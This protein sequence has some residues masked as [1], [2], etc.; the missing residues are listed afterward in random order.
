[1]RKLFSDGTYAEGWAVYSE[2]MMLKEGFR[3]GD[4]GLELQMLKMQLKVT[5]NAILDIKLHRGLMREDEVVPFLL[6]LFQTPGEAKAKLTRAKGTT[7]QLTTYYIG[8][9][10]MR[11]LRQE[12]ERRAGAGFTL[13]EFHR[14]VL[15]A[16]A[17]PMRF[18]RELVLQ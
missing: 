1:V 13:A 17:P 15:E 11:D 6:S 5:G 2:W 12:Y 8:Y 3:G 14:K 18:L 9:L 10:E 7:V 4:P 16:G